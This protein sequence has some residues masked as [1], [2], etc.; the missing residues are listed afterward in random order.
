V[1][2]IPIARQRLGK[3]IPAGANE[4]N[5]RTS[6]TRQRSCKHGFPTIERL[7]FL[8]GPCEVVIKRSS[9]ADEIRYSRVEFRDAS[10]PGYVLGSCRIMTRKELGREKKTSCVLHLQ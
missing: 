1:T 3:H 7:C 5:N 4:R 10:L 2:C 8:W 6:I 9:E